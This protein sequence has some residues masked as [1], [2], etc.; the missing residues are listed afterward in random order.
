MSTKEVQKRTKNKV[1]IPA[2]P[3]KKALADV[4]LCFKALV[5]PAAS[6]ALGYFCHLIG[7][8]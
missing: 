6:A 2:K 1:R 8:G 7:F 3:L 5:A 4:K